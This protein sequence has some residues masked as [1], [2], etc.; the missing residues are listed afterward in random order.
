[1]TIDKRAKLL[2]LNQCC[3]TCEHWD[4]SADR[5]R[6]EYR[7]SLGLNGY[8]AYNDKDPYDESIEHTWIIPETRQDFIHEEDVIDCKEYKPDR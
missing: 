5:T 4:F 8:V 3:S 2:L 7:C 1:M 6:I